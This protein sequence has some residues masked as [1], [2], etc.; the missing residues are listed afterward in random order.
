MQGAAVSRASVA[1]ALIA[2]VCVAAAATATGG[3]IFSPG[4]LHAGDS[5]P[6]T[7]QGVTS[8]AALGRQCGTCHGSPW[9]SVRMDAKCLECHS[10]VRRT[11]RDTSTLHGHLR[12]ASACVSCHTEHLG[13]TARL[14]RVDGFGAAHGQFGFSLAA[15]RTTSDGKIFG[16]NDCHASATFTF[17]DTRC[18]SCHR[19]YQ[20]AFVAR[21]VRE[22]GTDCQSCHDGIDRFT[23]SAFAHDTSGFTLDGAHVTA[24]CVSCHTETRTLADFG[25]AP[26]TCIGCHR[27]D[28]EHRGDLGDDCG[29]CHSTRSWEGATI[30]HDVFPLDHG[31]EGPVACKTCHEDPKNYKSYTCYNCHEHSRARVQAEHRGEVSTRNLDDCVRCHQGG[32]KE[33]REGHGEREGRRRGGGRGDD[34]S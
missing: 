14:T 5:T 29:A 24:S 17:D 21:H 10:D 32:E 12:D 7:L 20:G 18:E 31:E 1:V 25:T 28:D 23:R 30:E 19:D 2:A 15:H 26:T 34:H 33:G 6:A 16:C 9:S 11:L 13:R 3:G 27:A 8:H 4:A 22:W